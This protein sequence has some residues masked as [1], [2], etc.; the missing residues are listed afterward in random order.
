MKVRDDALCENDSEFF[1]YSTNL[2][3][4]F[5]LEHNYI[6][7]CGD[8]KKYF[9]SCWNFKEKVRIP[10][11]KK[12]FIIDGTKGYFFLQVGDIHEVIKCPYSK[13]K[14]LTGEAIACV[15]HSPSRSNYWHFSI[16]WRDK[17]GLYIS[18]T[19]SKWKYPLINSTRAALLEFGQIQ[20][21][22][23]I[24]CIPKDC[25]CKQ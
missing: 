18:Q 13:N 20:A 8:E 1:D 10:I 7:L 25:Y 3:G 15:V 17:D 22:K 9:R 16:K 2:L 5:Q 11:H 19:D 14:K 4:H 24:D 12:D 6:S 23:I 21:P